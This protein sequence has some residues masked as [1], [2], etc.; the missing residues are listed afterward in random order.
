MK[1]SRIAILTSAVMLVSV[2]SSVPASADNHG[3][4]D[5]R[6]GGHHQEGGRGPQGGPHGGPGGGFHGDHGGGFHGG[7]HGGPH[8]QG[9]GP[10][11]GNSFAWQ[12]H[13]FEPGRRFP[14]EYRGPHYWVNDW[15]NRGLPPPPYGHRWS[16]VDGNYVLV[17]IASGVITSI[18]LNSA[19]HP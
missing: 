8:W 2:I 19:L 12:G 14:H 17:A 5:Q 16:Y 3:Q 15:H 7:P 4:W 6:G 11:R 10:G 13:R 9:G 18:I 1:K